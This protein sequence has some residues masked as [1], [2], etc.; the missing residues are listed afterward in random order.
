MNILDNLENEI[1]SLLVKKRSRDTYKIPINYYDNIS[2][3]ELKQNINFNVFYINKLID[4]YIIIVK[5]LQNIDIDIVN[6]VIKYIL[7]NTKLPRREDKVKTYSFLNTLYYYLGY[8][9]ENK[10]DNTLYK[11]NNKYFEGKKQLISKL[12]QE[13]YIKIFS[14]IVCVYSL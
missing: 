8:N 7:K 5:E 14:N 13:D 3:K 2:K 4:K 1:V 12:V 10:D 11:R 9:E 6:L